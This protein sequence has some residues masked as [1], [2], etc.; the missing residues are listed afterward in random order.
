MS[1]RLVSQR[2][3][4]SRLDGPVQLHVRDNYA[5]WPYSTCHDMLTVLVPKSC[6]IILEL[7]LNYGCRRQA[8]AIRHQ[9]S[10]DRGRVRV[11]PNRLPAAADELLN[12]QERV[13]KSKVIL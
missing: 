9:P 5:E 1:R 7:R 13:L 3:R 6:R 2:T 4:C 11:R 12:G 10:I 8:Y